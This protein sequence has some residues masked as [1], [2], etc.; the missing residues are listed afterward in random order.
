M[1]TNGH[2]GEEEIRAVIEHGGK[3]ISISLDTLKPA[4]QEHINGGFRKSW[5]AALQAMALFTQHLPVDSSFASLGCVL[6]PENIGD[7]EQ[8]IRFGTEISWFTSLVPIHITKHSRPMG[9]RTYDQSLRFQP[10][11]YPRVNALI[12]KVRKMRKEGF[13]LYDS[14]QYLDDIKRFVQRKPTTWRNRTAVSA[15]VRIS[16]LPCCQTAMWLPAAIIG[17]RDQSPPMQ[18]NSPRYSVTASFVPRS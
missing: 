1:Q 11:H 2:A 5:D 3:D 6:S 4:L 14:D 7:V 9:F 16:I 12:E 13:L 15:I 18:R 10:E 17:C 8:V